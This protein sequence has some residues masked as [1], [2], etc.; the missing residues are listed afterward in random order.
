MVLS[1]AFGDTSM[2]YSVGD[3][4]VSLGLAAVIGAYIYAKHQAYKKRL[5][6]VHEERMTAMEKGIPLPEFPFEKAKEPNEAD[7]LVIPLLG[8]VLTTLSLGAMIVLYLNG[9]AQSRGFW[10][11]PLPFTFLGIGFLAFHFLSREKKR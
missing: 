10:I 11:A 9:T 2:S 8:V 6:I 5:E 7:R 1:Y 4:I 3:G